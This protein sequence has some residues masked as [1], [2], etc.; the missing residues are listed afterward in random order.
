M[1]SQKEFKALI[2]PHLGASY[3]LALWLMR[4]PH[5]AEDVVQESY[6]KA[7]NAF[8]QFKGENPKGWLLSIVRNTCMTLLSRNMRQSKVVPIEIALDSP[9]IWR[10]DQH[11]VEPMTSPV[12]QLIS[13]HESREVRKAVS[14][15][16]VEFREV[17]V[18]REFEDMAYQQI[19]DITGVPVGTVM[20][21]LSRA[22]K[23]LHAVLAPIIEEGHS[24]EM[25]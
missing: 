12:D 1:S 24:H 18:L 19:A 15:L 4:T 21:R 20:S 14:Q 8:D 9:G 3:N 10:A 6:L 13:A 16:P 2:L 5:D 7:F 11:L 23:K 17:I 22:R 25:P